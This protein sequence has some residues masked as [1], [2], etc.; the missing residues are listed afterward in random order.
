META[1]G[2]RNGGVAVVSKLRPINDLQSYTIGATDGDIGTI[3]DVY[4][5]DQSWTAR[6]L[7]VD[8]GRWLSGRQVLIPP[9]ALRE[10]DAAGQRVITNL[11]KQQVQDSPS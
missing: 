5:D 6:Y 1:K 7:V 8:T 11:T 4:F 10:I 2:P 9:R 3:Q